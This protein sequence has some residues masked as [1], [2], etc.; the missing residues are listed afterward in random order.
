MAAKIKGTFQDTSDATFQGFPWIHFFGMTGYISR[1]LAVTWN[2][3]FQAFCS[4]VICISE[5]YICVF[6]ATQY[7][8]FLR[9]LWAFKMWY[10]LIYMYLS[11]QLTAKLNGKKTFTSEIKN[12]SKICGSAV[13]GLVSC[14][15]LFKAT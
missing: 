12:A 2:G 13:Y 3:P 9:K 11:P 5:A 14:I 7:L 10:Y 15:F 6:K 1:F 4:M 8:A